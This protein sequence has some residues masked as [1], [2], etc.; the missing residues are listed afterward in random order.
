MRA[1]TLYIIPVAAGALAKLSFR[2]LGEVRLAAVLA[3]AE[4][5]VLA[6][7]KQHISKL[8][9]RGQRSS[10]PFDNGFAA[11]YS[12]NCGY[13]VRLEKPLGIFGIGSGG[14]FRQMKVQKPRL[15][16]K[17]V[18]VEPSLSAVGHTVLLDKF[19]CLFRGV[20]TVFPKI[21]YHKI[22]LRNR[23]YIVKGTVF[24]HVRIRCRR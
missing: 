16:G 9:R 5:A 11:V 22:V 6:S 20:R 24:A 18:G 21:T 13:G 14:N 7:E 12:D 2:I 3:D 4:P 19:Q 1:M 23:G 10:L 17:F 8:N 15:L